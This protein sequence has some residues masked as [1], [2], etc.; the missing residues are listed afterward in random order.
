MKSESKRAS[1]VKLRRGRYR[2]E[3]SISTLDFDTT[4]ECRDNHTNQTRSLDIDT[5]ASIS[6]IVI[7]IDWSWT[8]RA[9]T[10]A[11]ISTSG[12]DID[13]TSTEDKSD[14]EARILKSIIEA[15]SYLVLLDISSCL[16]SFP[17]SFIK[18][19]DLS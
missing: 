13:P 19:K 11:S 18:I 3:T 5:H 16:L 8:S 6:T 17:L 10:Q 1:R 9:E 4:S 14:F 2:L 15:M 7:D 12:V